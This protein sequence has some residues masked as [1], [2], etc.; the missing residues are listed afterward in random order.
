M[1]HQAVTCGT[2]AARNALGILTDTFANLC[3]ALACVLP[4]VAAHTTLEH[5]HMHLQT[6]LEEDLL[7]HALHMLLLAMANIHIAVL[8]LIHLH[9][10]TSS[11]LHTPASP[12]LCPLHDWTLHTD[13]NPP[14]QHSVMCYAAPLKHS[15]IAS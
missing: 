11:T 14:H 2:P 4:V 6:A 12:F 10:T 15:S 7:P 5:V 13:I 9:S 3:D 8:E 1:A